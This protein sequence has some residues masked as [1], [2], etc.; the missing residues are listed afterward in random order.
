MN[1]LIESDPELYEADDEKNPEK[2]DKKRDVQLDDLFNTSEISLEDP[3]E[4]REAYAIKKEEESKI[5][6][7][8]TGPYPLDPSEFSHTDKGENAQF[9]YF[10]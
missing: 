10:N 6:N 5:H 3:E 8:F 1:E 7:S 9:C 4:F 2:N